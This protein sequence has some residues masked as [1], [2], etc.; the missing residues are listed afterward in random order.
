MVNQAFIVQRSESPS[1]GTSTYILATGFAGI[2][3]KIA[4]CDGVLHLHQYQE[5]WMRTNIIHVL[6]DASTHNESS[7]ILSQL[8]GHQNKT[9]HYL[10]F[11]GE[12]K[13][14]KQNK[15]TESQQIHSNMHVGIDT[16]TI[17]G[18]DYAVT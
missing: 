3:K 12:S 15:A 7:C 17:K 2:Q 13:R 14:S 10:L 16:C 9:M 1:A 18:A 8:S 11:I 5:Y 4:R 6:K